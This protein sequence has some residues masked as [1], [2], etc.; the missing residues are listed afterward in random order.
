MVV[1]PTCRHH[2][3]TCM[4]KRKNTGRKLNRLK[5]VL[6]TQGKTQTWLSEQMDLDFETINRYTN[7]H[8]Q[9]TIETLFE[10]ARILK[11]NPKDLLNA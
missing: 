3:F 7:N 8:R 11:V 9:P 2:Y 10:I 5:E 4:G 1:Y 6:S